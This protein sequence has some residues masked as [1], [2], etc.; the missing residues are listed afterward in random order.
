[1]KLLSEMA[2]RKI[3]VTSPKGGRG[4]TTVAVNLAVT[5]AM[6]GITT[7]LVDADSHNIGAMQ[8]H[9]HLAE[10][11]TTMIHLLRQRALGLAGA[12]ETMHNIA[13]GATILDSF[14][15]M[16]ALPTLKVLPGLR[17]EDLADT[18]L[19]NEELID[20]TIDE[21]C[22]TCVASGGIVVMDV[23]K[24]IYH[25]VHRSALRYADTF[26]IVI[27]PEVPDLSE[28]RRWISRMVN[29]LARVTSPRV[30]FEYVSSKVKLCF[31]MVVGDVK[32]LPRVSLKASEEGELDSIYL[33]SGILPLV[34]HNLVTQ[35][36]NGDSP[37]N[38]FI[39]RYE[40]SKLKEL[41]PFADALFE[42][43]SHL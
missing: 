32:A 31:N 10:I 27:K 26:V 28:T 42:L 4:K 2:A 6:A 3:A 11:K 40:E 17:A 7:Y 29:P 14:T 33:P 25:P 18:V 30:A 13:S 15:T 22:E 23:G 12:S 39:W 20:S 37:Q 38:I 21:L 8:G 35:A 9:L 1:M 43:A 16:D 34:D 41:A 5:F 36:V 24:N 19:L